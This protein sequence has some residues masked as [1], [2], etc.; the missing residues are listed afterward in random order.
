M[1]ITIATNTNTNIANGFTLAAQGDEFY[2]PFQTNVFATGASFSGVVTS[3]VGGIVEDYGAFVGFQYGI[4]IG[5][6]GTKSQVVIGATGTVSGYSLAAISIVAN[7]T[8]GGYTLDNF[9]QVTGVGNAA[10]VIVN[11]NGQI[12]N[13]GTIAGS[14][15]I[16]Q[17]GIT[18]GDT[19][20]LTNT[21]TGVIVGGYNGGASTISES[22]NNR[23]LIRGNVTLGSAANNFM[24]NSGT[25]S[26][27]SGTV[28][29]GNG[30]ND[31]FQNFGG[32]GAL[33]MGNGTSDVVLNFG[34]IGNIN[35]GSGAGDYVGNA[36]RI[37]GNV[38]MGNG[39]GQVF[40]STHG[41]IYNVNNPGGAGTISAGS[42]GATIVGA[43]N[44]GGI[45]GGAGNDVLIANQTTSASFDYNARTDMHALGGTNAMYG[46]TGINV[47]FSGDA[48][49]NQIW[50]GRA[51]FTSTGNGYENNSVDYAP[52][53]GANRSVFV[54]L[55]NGHD[56]FVINAGVYTYADSIVNVPN[57][58]ATAGA[59][60]IQCDNEVD[61]ITGRA[62][63]D[64]LYAGSGSFSQV[65]FI[66]TG[67]SD[68]NTVTGYDTI[69]GFKIGV[70]KIDLSALHTDGSHLAIST[71]GTSNTLYV[72]QTA[73]TF[74]AN[75]DLA[76][77]VNTSTAG[78]LHASDFVF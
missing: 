78:G 13:T 3:G 8:G 35:M 75:T 22:L 25:G 32:M 77:I 63:G 23:G 1:T 12:N 18:G 42:T 67:Y 74:N 66:Y 16:S 57:V 31:H 49:Y 34:T 6:I 36:G 60:I 65:G 2:V 21:E 4:N 40:D 9:G 26:I 76:M 64:S 28:T 33:V 24:T 68:S 14:T 51:A 48:T 15:G 59:D 73:G 7:A 41:T 10:G 61:R 39:A 44:G 58:L 72:E 55:L 70:D 43:L 29:F 53:V 11:G 19:F 20:S 52:V 30:N 56:A 47:F 5:A 69:V 46:G 62:S 54:D 45:N 50:G 27:T 37:D 71:A 38:V 17:V